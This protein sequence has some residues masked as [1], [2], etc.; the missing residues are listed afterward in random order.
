MDFRISDT[1]TDSLAKVTFDEQK[2][3]KGAV[4]CLQDGYSMTGA[5]P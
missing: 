1:F 3:V 4:I 2:R 5:L